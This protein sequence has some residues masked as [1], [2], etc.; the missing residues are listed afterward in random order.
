MAAAQELCDPRDPLIMVASDDIH[1]GH[2]GVGGVA[3]CRPVEPPD[4]RL[5]NAA[6]KR[7]APVPEHAR[8]RHRGSHPEREARCSCGT[9]VTG[10]PLASP[11]GTSTW[12]HL[13]DRFINTAAELLDEDSLLRTF[14]VDCETPLSAVSGLDVKGLMRFEPCGQGNPKPVLLSRN[15]KVMRTKTVGAGGEHLT[16]TLKDGP[17]TWPAIA[18][19]QGE[20]DVANEVD[21]VYSF[22]RDWGGDQL[23]LEVHDFA[24]SGVGRPLED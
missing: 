6:Q 22:S 15:V 20:N 23:K 3:V 24:P 9:V 21:I 4:D 14:T 11:S 5:S 1:A 13:R 2:R 7:A 12:K 18:F 8:V 16:M 19:R 17:L 10:R